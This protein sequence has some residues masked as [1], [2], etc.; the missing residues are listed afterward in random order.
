MQFAR[1]DE[2]KSNGQNVTIDIDIL[3]L[4]VSSS[5][6][7]ELNRWAC[8]AT[9]RRAYAAAVAH[10]YTVAAVAQHFDHA[11]RAFVANAFHGGGLRTIKAHYRVK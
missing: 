10:G 3:G 11:A 4:S 1:S 7:S 6:V 8:H 5:K 9:R 2:V